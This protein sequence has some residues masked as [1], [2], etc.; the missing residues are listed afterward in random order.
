MDYNAAMIAATFVN[1]MT[2]K[3][4][5]VKVSDLVLDFGGKQRPTPDEIERKAL[6]I[7]KRINAAHAAKEK[8]KEH[9]GDRR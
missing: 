1:V 4:T 7:A 8:E 3:R 9:G 2:D 5:T 6:V